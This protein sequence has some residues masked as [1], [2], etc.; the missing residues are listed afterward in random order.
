MSTA[1][2]LER[3]PT[4]PTGADAQKKREAE[5]EGEE[6]TSVATTSFAAVATA[7][8][9][10]QAATWGGRQTFAL[11]AAGKARELSTQARVDGDHQ[12]NLDVSLFVAYV[13]AYATENQ[14]F[15]QFLY[16]RFPPRLKTAVDAWLATKPRTS[17]DAPP[18]PF[19]MREYRIEAHERSASLAQ[20]SDDLV[21]KATN[22]NARS[23]TYVLGT[24]VFATIILLGSLGARLRVRRPRRAMLIASVVALLVSIAWVVTMPIAWVGI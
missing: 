4:A 12:A 16:D 13:Q 10:F 17:P 5:R 19:V 15:A 20:Q 21:V 23:D 7:W 24:V 3:A 9:A 6:V 22:A 11:A 2:R 8:C 18:H 1:D 14:T